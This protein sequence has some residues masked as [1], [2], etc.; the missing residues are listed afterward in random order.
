MMK[1]LSGLQGVLLILIGYLEFEGGHQAERHT[2]LLP[3]STL[4]QTSPE[5]NTTKTKKKTK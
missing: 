2:V 1:Q 3:E 5:K 4:I